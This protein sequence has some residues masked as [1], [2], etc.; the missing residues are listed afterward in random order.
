VLKRL[1]EIIGR[2]P[3]RIP[4]PHAIAA[5]GLRA[6]EQLGF[7]PPIDPGQLTMLREGSVVHDPKGNALVT[8][9]GVTPTPLQAGLEQLAGSQPEQ[10]PEEGIGSLER[11]RFWVDVRGSRMTAEQLVEH[12]AKRFADVTPWTM[13]FDAEP[14]SPRAIDEGVTLTMQL[15]LRGRIQVRVEDIAPRHITLVTLKGHPLAGAVRLQAEDRADGMVRFEIRV[16]D[17]AADI[18]DWL[19]MN[20][21]GAQV[22]NATWRALL[23]QVVT[24]S[25]GESP[26]GIQQE[27]DT[28]D[29]RETKKVETWIADVVRA[30]KRAERAGERAETVDPGGET[31]PEQRV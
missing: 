3:L 6:V 21:V 29:E 1:G 28:L 15:P 2:Q 31:P 10:L 5:L 23:D 24:D 7:T 11:K 27:S 13:N 20:P 12:V 26:D 8:V 9:L 19:A 22:Q 30:R 25:G 14:G 18:V 17:R 16:Y 4:V